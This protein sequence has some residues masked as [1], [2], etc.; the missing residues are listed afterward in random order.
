MP[1]LNYAC[2]LATVKLAMAH[3]LLNCLA[4]DE[5][6]NTAGRRLSISHIES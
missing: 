4:W 3:P 1:V 2:T 6:A 5:S